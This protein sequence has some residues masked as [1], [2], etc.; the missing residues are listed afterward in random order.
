MSGAVNGTWAERETRGIFDQGSR[1]APGQRVVRG[2]STEGSI[3]ALLPPPVVFA[4]APSPIMARKKNAPPNVIAR[5]RK[6]RH[7]YAIEDTLEAGIALEGWEVKSLRD[8]RLQLRDS[9]AA[10]RNGEI[11][12]SGAHISPLGTVSTH[13]TPRPLRERKLLLKRAEISRLVGAVERR[14]YTLIALDMH[15]TRNRAKVLLAT[16]RG[17]KRHDKRTAEKDR[18]WERERAR[19]LRARR[20]QAPGL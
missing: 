4:S 15:W 18:D 8:G 10:I 17:K 7:D 13:V 20:E 11:W 19:L 16:A 12:L 14:G 9:F 2:G 3:R 5:N 6:A 1:A